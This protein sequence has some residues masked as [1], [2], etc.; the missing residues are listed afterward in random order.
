MSDSSPPLAD[1]GPTEASPVPVPDASSPDVVVEL[2]PPWFNPP[3]GQISENTPVVIE[4]APDRPSDAFIYYTTD[5]T[6]P[7]HASP[8]YVQ[9]LTI[10]GPF[11]TIRAMVGG[12][13]YQDSPTVSATYT[14]PVPC[15]DGG[16]EV[17]TVPTFEPSS[18]TQWHPI[19]LTLSS[20]PLTGVTICYTFDGTVPTCNTGACTGVSHTYE[21]PITIDGTVTGPSGTVRVNALECAAGYLNGIDMSQVYT[22]QL[23]PPYVASSNADGAGLPGWSWTDGGAPATTM[24][25]PGDAGVP[26]GPFTASQVGDTPCTG[27]ATCT[28]APDQLADFLCWSKNATATCSCA[29]PL[30]ITPASPAPAV[31]ADVTPGDTLSVIACVSSPSGNGAAGYLDS[32][33]TTVQF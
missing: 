9:P 7:T 17:S 4:A 18:G 31:P 23:A 19:T 1:A 29:S 14:W 32:T 8:V 33:P 11:E 26:Y 21:N 24:T 2:A 28:G 20:A 6:R 12:V 5:G 22:L 15:A 16:C 3:A 13:G 25:I 10:D 30:P 27:P